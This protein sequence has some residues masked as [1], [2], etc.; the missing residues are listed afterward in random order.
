MA[1]YPCNESDLEL[2]SEWSNVPC[3]HTDRKCLIIQWCRRSPSEVSDA[4]SQ[5]PPNGKGG[6]IDITSRERHDPE[7]RRGDKFLTQGSTTK[8]VA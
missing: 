8:V 1:D 2:A 5:I 3:R 4:L 7:S 6:G